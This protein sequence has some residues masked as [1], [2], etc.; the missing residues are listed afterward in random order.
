MAYKFTITQRINTALALATVFFL[1]LATNQIDKN[2]FETAQNTLKTVFEDRV[3]AQDYI[4]NINNIVFEK[5][6]LLEKSEENYKPI[7]NGELS[8]L[9]NNFGNTKLTTDE[10]KHYNLLQENFNKLEKVFNAK[11]LDNNTKSSVLNLLIDMNDNLNSLSKIQLKESKYLTGVAQKSLDMNNLISNVEIALL[12]IIGII[13]QLV[14]FYRNKK[15]T[16]RL[17]NEAQN[18]NK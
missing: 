11:P 8:K 15:S 10:S 7:L 1:V 2:H 4:H 5:R 17:L 3:V 16:K 14:I 9:I 6:L 18:L 13:F 12:I